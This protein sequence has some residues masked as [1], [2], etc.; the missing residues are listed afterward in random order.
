MS[1][2]LWFEDDCA[3]LGLWLEAAGPFPPTE[4][5][6]P[7]PLPSSAIKAVLWAANASFILACILTSNCSIRVWMSASDAIGLVEVDEIGDNTVGV[8]GTNV[9]T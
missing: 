4:A 1:S 7:L 8:A 5:P 3:A 9:G 6:F 2:K